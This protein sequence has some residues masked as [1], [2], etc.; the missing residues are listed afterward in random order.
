MSSP[1]RS[2]HVSLVALLLVSLLLV[3]PGG[4][5]TSQAG[6]PQARQASTTPERLVVLATADLMG[7]TS[8]C[9]CHTPKGGFSRIG[10]F[11]DS[12]RATGQATLY[13]DA[14]GAFPVNVGRTDLARFMFQTMQQLA[15]G[16]V[17]VAPRDLHLGVAFLRDVARRS[18]LP[19][20]C[21]NLV[22][23]RSRA[24]L[25]PT[26]RLVQASGVTVGVFA[27]VGERFDLGPA[28]DSV[29]V[30]DPENAAHEA[31][32]SLRSRGARVIV[33]LSQ[34]GRVGGE[35]I[36]SAVPGIDAVILGRDIPL[37]E[38]GRRIGSTLLSY[39]GDRGQH[40]GVVT[41][42]L[43]GSARA[44]D[45]TCDIRALGPDVREHPA[46][47]ASVRRFEDAYNERMRKE[48]RSERAAH[49]ADSDPVDHFVG[50]SVCGRCHPAEAEQ[51]L[52]TAHSL[53]WETL[54]RE[55]KDATPEC[56]PCHV[57][58]YRQP[59]GFQSAS[60]TPHLVN[61]QCENCH[62]MGTLH[63]ESWLARSGLGEATC[64]TCHNAE[65]DP[66]FDYATRL[67][68]VTHGNSSGESIRVVKARRERGYS[69]GS[70]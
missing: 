21:A 37:L 61:V 7:E 19:L 16:A 24:P 60:A 33:L 62:G 46:L 68:L 12:T 11:V 29:A 14:G 1:S 36:A 23:R 22:D 47:L 50:D 5:R 51:W 57:V 43:D 42:A 8:P 69:S 4:S 52:T 27:L 25:F 40:L 41:L 13:V 34:L 15:P 59:G 18:G 48:Q 20:T 35:D 38:H 55:R 45:G 26:T 67:P 32:A 10:T 64:R 31:V 3:A 39:A 56:V 63:V 30:L 2:Q 9:G 58:G 49:D 44:V 17:G 6:M 65:R 54:V 70:H 66:E 28:R 53:A